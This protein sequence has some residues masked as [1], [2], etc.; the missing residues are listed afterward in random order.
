MDERERQVE[1]QAVV[2]KELQH[3][4]RNLF[5]IIEAVATRSLTPPAVPV[6]ARDSFLR[7]LHDLAEAYTLSDADRGGRLLDVLRHM[8]RLNQARIDITGC[9]VVL[10]PEVQQ[11][12]VLVVHELQTNAMKYGALSGA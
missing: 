8:L 6:S 10:P 9:D 1:R 4:L 3:R 7:R 2:I 12:T 11:D 5:G